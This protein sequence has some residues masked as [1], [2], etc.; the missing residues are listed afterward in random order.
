MFFLSFFSAVFLCMQPTCKWN[1]KM[2]DPALLCA[3]WR[4]TPAPYILR[5]GAKWAEAG[6][7]FDVHGE[8]VCLTPAF[9]SRLVKTVD[10]P[11]LLQRRTTSDMGVTQVPVACCLNRE[12]YY[13]AISHHVIQGCT[14]AE[15][16]G[17]L[18]V[19]TQREGAALLL[20]R[21]LHWPPAS[22]GKCRNQPR[23]KKR[24]SVLMEDDQ[25]TSV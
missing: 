20:F 5:S 15:K 7:S 23:Q 25:P 1:P 4:F 13:S 19:F 18:S 12:L 3:P 14:R 17:F 6:C 16:E 21:E 2:L 10:S 11:S 8:S 9:Y 22:H 24:I